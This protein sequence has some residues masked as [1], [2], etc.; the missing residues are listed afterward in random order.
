MAP[1]SITIAVCCYNSARRLPDTLRHL[2][3]Q[4]VPDDVS[5][6]V[7]VI[8]NAS[9]DGTADVA[10]QTWPSDAPAPLRVVTEPNAG[11]SNARHRAIMEARYDVIGF[12][13]DDNWVCQDWVQTASKTMSAHP[14]AGA[15]GGPSEAVFEVSPPDWFARYKA[16]YAVGEQA[17]AEGDVTDTRG[18]LWGAGLCLRRQALLQLFSAGFSPLLS[19]RKGSQ[20]TSGGDNELC[21]ALVMAGWRVWY[22]PRLELRHF[23]PKERLTSDYLK[24]WFTGAGACSVLA[25]IYEHVLGLDELPAHRDIAWYQLAYW[26]LISTARRM[27]DV[28]RKYGRASIPLEDEVAIL[29]GKAALMKYLSVSWRYQSYCSAIRGAP[30][31]RRGVD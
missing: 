2:A 16:C 12:I 28:R 9:T 31:A 4:V 1:A 25:G 22:N 8:D 15:C 5:W 30:W 20:L 14:E 19:D 13:D 10:L 29:S 17:D 11:L 7:L 26:Q 18:W 3:A 21:Y 24:R 23:I 6:E 27:T